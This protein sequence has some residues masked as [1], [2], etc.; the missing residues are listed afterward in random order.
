MLEGARGRQ[1][2]RSYKSPHGF[3]S[4]WCSEKGVFCCFSSKDEHEG[5]GIA[6]ENS[7]AALTF[8]ATNYVPVFDGILYKAIDVFL[9]CISS[10]FGH[11]VDRLFEQ[12]WAAGLAVKTSS[13]LLEED[14]SGFSAIAS[15]HYITPR[16]MGPTQKT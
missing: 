8:Y 9:F 13:G 5:H 1:T 10:T 6:V 3:L 2:P 14:G 16:G 11:R 15:D 4:N 12:V 7:K